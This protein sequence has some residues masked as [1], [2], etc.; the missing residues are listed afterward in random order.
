MYRS[1]WNLCNVAHLFSLSKKAILPINATSWSSSPS[2][3]LYLCSSHSLSANVGCIYLFYLGMSDSWVCSSACCNR[4]ICRNCQKWR[5]QSLNQC[6][7]DWVQCVL[8]VYLTVSECLEAISW[9]AG[10][11]PF[12]SPHLNQ[13]S[14]CHTPRRAW[15]A[16]KQHCC[17]LYATALWL[18]QNRPK[19]SWG[20]V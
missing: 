7:R 2:A 14:L 11:P 5:R 4:G 10:Y 15:T 1:T 17:M 19:L 8:H 16:L 12:T 3:A 6:S 20:S 13:T 9:Q 18:I